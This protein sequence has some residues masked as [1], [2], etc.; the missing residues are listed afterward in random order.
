WSWLFRKSRASSAEPA[1]FTS[2]FRLSSS[3]LRANRATLE[4]STSRAFLI[5]MSLPQPVT[6]KRVGAATGLL[7]PAFQLRALRCPVTLVPITHAG[8]CGAGCEYFTGRSR[9]ANLSV[10]FAMAECCFDGAAVGVA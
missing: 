2:M 4:S 6:A 1:M 9:Q 10:G 5:A 8:L 3:L 7:L